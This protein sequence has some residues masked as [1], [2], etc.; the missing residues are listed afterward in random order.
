MNEKHEFWLY[1]DSKQVADKLTEFHTNWYSWHGSPF[2][3]MW[4]RN[5]LSYY[6]PV[7]HPSAWDTSLIF[8]GIQGELLRFYTPK[9]RSLIRQL[10]AVVTKQ[11]MAFKASART[12]GAEV[13][14]EVKLANALSDQII[15]T[16]RLDLKGDQLCEGGLV[17]GVWFTKTTWRTD[18]GEPYTR[19][20]DGKPITNGG[21]EIALLSPFNVFYNVQMPWDQLPWVECR[22]KRN[23]WDLIA[24]HKDLEREIKALPSVSEER[25]PHSWV[26]ST[27]DDDDLVYV[28]EFYHKPS[29]ALP[30]GRM[31]IYAD[32]ETVFYDGENR[33]GCI[34]IE[35]NIPEAV[36]DTGLGYSK[37]T[38]LAGAQ[39]M[40]DNSLSAIAT[41]QSQ[42]AVQNVA[43]PRGSNVN[44]NQLNGMNFISFT[45]Q[46][47]PGGGKPEAL[48]L[49][50]TAPETFKFTDKLEQLMQDLSF[51]NGAMTGNLP[52][53]VSSGTAIATLSAN[54]IEF[55]TS[56]S[57]SYNLCWEKTMMHAMNAYQRFAKIPQKVKLTQKGGQTTYKEFTG[58][59]VGNVSEMKLEVVNPLMKTFAGRLEIG[60]KL[61]SMPQE[62]W[63]EYTAILEGRPLSEIYKG[64]VQETDL[65]SQE[66][67]ALEN[68]QSVPVLAVDDHPLHIQRHSEILADVGNRMNGESVQAVLDHI[69][70][71]YSQLKQ[72]DPAL[73]G[74]IKTGRIPEGGLQ[75]PPAP[76]A[77]GGPPPAAMAP[78]GAPPPDMP[79]S[80]ADQPQ[81]V[82]PVMGDV[83]EPS[84]DLLGRG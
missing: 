16:E 84:A 38:D 34:P 77:Q 11:R 35:P 67:E 68:G 59:D 14:N 66:N 57:K 69:M 17:T 15:Q 2:K 70:E 49:T 5:Y 37:L 12:T 45:P 44:V 62:I 10:T 30:K 18:F 7:V 26:D 80:G 4:L 71:H 29:P 52:A 54:S 20:D 42:F 41:N 73:L 78:Q 31:L 56:I 65:I 60:E 46:N 81:S 64:E 55:I 53:G 51:L 21:V 22:V 76:P 72:G 25:G 40:F 83:A 79:Q 3:Q 74:I 43:V 63:P 58:S 82:N 19:D 50:K 32:S 36:L 75:P 48:Q 6:S 13:L 8:E 28:Y 24:D 33:Y 23:R 9:A 47:V 39:E 1:G 27:L 61:L